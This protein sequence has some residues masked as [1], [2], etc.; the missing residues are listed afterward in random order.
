MLQE[1]LF[2]TMEKSEVV[3]LIFHFYMDIVELVVSANR[4]IAHSGVGTLS[5]FTEM[6]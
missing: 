6:P 3:S 5:C 2:A 1:L 4:L